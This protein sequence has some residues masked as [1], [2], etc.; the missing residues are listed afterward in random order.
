MSLII[1]YTQLAEDHQNL[2]VL[3]NQT[4]SLISNK[5]YNRAWERIHKCNC[6]S[7]PGQTRKAWVRYE[8]NYPTENNEWGDFQAHAGLA[9]GSDPL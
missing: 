4:G 1:D 9:V 2:L 6:I 7:I 8:R 3:V 5:T